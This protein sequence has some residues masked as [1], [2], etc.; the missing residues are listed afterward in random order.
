MLPRLKDSFV[1]KLWRSLYDFIWPRQNEKGKQ[2]VKISLEEHL[3]PCFFSS[4]ILGDLCLITSGVAGCIRYADGADVD[5]QT[6]QSTPMTL[7]KT[8]ASDQEC[9]KQ[10]PHEDSP[11]YETKTGQ[12][13]EQLRA[14]AGSQGALNF[15]EHQANPASCRSL[16][17]P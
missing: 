6:V 11:K 16:G 5:G 8:R 3:L 10:L 1:L 7:W 2:Y 4:Q 15:Q 9:A 17:K 14:A 13:A 12:E